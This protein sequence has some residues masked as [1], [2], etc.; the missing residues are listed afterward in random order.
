MKNKGP[1]KKILDIDIWVDKKMYTLQIL[2]EKYIEKI[3]IYFGIENGKT[4]SM[5]LAS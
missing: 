3:L 5:L 2:Q 1:I 4:V